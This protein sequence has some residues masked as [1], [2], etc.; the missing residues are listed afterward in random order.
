MSRRHVHAEVSRLSGRRVGLL[1]GSFN[2]AHEGH[3]H[4][5]EA[6]IAQLRLDEVW[7]L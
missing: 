4:I 6:A 5:S 3:L 1:G 2:P 7:W